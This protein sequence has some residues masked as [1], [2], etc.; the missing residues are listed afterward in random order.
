VCIIISISISDNVYATKMFQELEKRKST[1]KVLDRSLIEAELEILFSPAKF[2]I[3]I[4]LEGIIDFCA[5]NE[6]ADW[7]LLMIS[8]R[9]EW[10]SDLNSFKEVRGCLKTSDLTTKCDKLK[11]FT[12]SKCIRTCLR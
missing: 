9:H 11:P 1:F 8:Q 10:K 4:V 6:P 5:R 3:A 12:F 7:D 2:T